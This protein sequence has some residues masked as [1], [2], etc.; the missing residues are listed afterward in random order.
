MCIIDL[1]ME[2]IDSGTRLVEKIRSDGFPGPI[3]MLSSVGDALSLQ[4]DQ[5]T[6]GLDGVLQKPIEPGLL[7]KLVEAKLK[8][9]R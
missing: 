6:L 9:K 3:V 7:L 8:L 5:F 2:D 1:L 4:A